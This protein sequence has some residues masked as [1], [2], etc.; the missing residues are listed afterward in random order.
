MLLHPRNRP[1]FKNLNTY[2]LLVERFLEHC[3]GEIGY[4]ALH[5]TGAKSEGILFFDPEG[6]VNA[7]FE[8]GEVRL[9]GAA[10][11]AAMLD[12]VEGEGYFSLDVYRFTAESA[13]LWANSPHAKPLYTGLGSEFTNLAG[14]LDK[15]S[16]EHLT[17]YAE[18][19]LHGKEGGALVL[20]DD[21]IIVG[22]S[23]D[24]EEAGEDDDANLELLLDK[25][26]VSGGVFNVYRIAFHS[27]EDAAAR[28]EERLLS[29]I[30]A[31]Q[32][33][34]NHLEDAL[35]IKHKIKP[36]ELRS[37]LNRKFLQKADE[38]PFLDPF[39]KEI[40]YSARRLNHYGTT[41][42]VDLMRALTSVCRECA[43]ESRIEKLY[44]ERFS[45]WRKK[46]AWLL[47]DLNV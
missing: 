45:Q 11:E 41:A 42:P 46:Y 29:T 19:A 21:G 31:L 3:Q 33:L 25:A 18:V 43:L 20:F 37:L 7:A 34:M 30:E 8:E 24:F 5:F 47:S 15:L 35:T 36:Q 44:D 12:A 2:Y 14:L 1:F 13:I 22:G 38:F 27:E 6:V 39:A 4:G 10:A 16:Q 9:E 17:G 40:E 26:E 28:E 23:Y 32:N